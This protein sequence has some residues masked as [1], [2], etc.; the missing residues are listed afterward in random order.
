[1]L[2]LGW[3]KYLFQLMTRDKDWLVTTFVKYI[4]NK[5]EK[6]FSHI[7]S[8]YCFS[9]FGQASGNGVFGQG[10]FF[11]GLGGAPS[12]ENA[13]KNVFGG[14]GNLANSSSESTSKIFKFLLSCNW[15]SCLKNSSSSKFF[16]YL[17]IFF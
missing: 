10:S 1:M 11:S 15:T 12:A 17:F 7:W 9:G 6:Y 5:K 8:F 2:I 3:T 13:N 4:F 14:V 16:F